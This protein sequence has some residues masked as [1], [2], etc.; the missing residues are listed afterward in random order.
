MKKLFIIYGIGE[1]LYFYLLNV[2]SQL[3]FWLLLASCIWSVETKLSKCH[4]DSYSREYIMCEYDFR[5]F[6]QETSFAIFFA[7]KFRTLKN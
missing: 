3:S 5:I 1:Y 4:Q 7:E 6:F 2:A